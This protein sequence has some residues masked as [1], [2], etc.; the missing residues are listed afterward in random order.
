MFGVWLE[1]VLKTIKT[2]KDHRYKVSHLRRDG[3]ASKMGHP[4]FVIGTCCCGVTHYWEW[5]IKNEQAKMSRPD[6]S[7]LLHQKIQRLLRESVS[8]DLDA[9]RGGCR[10]AGWGALVGEQANVYAAVLGAAF[11]GRVVGDFLILADADQIEAVGGDGILRREVLNDGVGAA[12]AKLVVVV[13]V[14]G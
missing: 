4:A 14:A 13:G 2:V 10:S 8:P 5:S 12:L 6:I 3:A 11:A 7:G 9:A 1:G